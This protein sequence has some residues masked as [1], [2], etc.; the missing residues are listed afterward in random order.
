[1]N[2]DDPLNCCCLRQATKVQRT[3]KGSL[4]TFADPSKKVGALMANRKVRCAE[5]PAPD[6]D[7]QPVLLR[8]AATATWCLRYD[9]VDSRGHT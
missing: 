3:A 9:C 6:L 4:V 8:M 2:R 7:C 5:P 1:M